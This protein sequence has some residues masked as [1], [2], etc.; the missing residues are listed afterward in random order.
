MSG[1][2]T[3]M[4]QAAALLLVAAALGFVIGRAARR[5]PVA[6]AA[7][8]GVV[9]RSEPTGA[10]AAAVGGNSPLGELDPPGTGVPEEMPAP[11]GVPAEAEAVS[12][13]EQPVAASGEPVPST[14]SATAAEDPENPVFDAV[15]LLRQG[16]AEVASPEVAAGSAEP[17]DDLA[18]EST[19]EA[20]AD[21]GP[22]TPSADGSE[23][24]ADPAEVAAL[25]RAK[26][27]EIGRLESGALTALERTISRFQGRVDDL[28]ARLKDATSRSR[29]LDARAEEEA[30]RARRL[31]ETL[32]RRD[33]DVAELRD[34]LEARR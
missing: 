9:R 31:Q 5:G 20:V 7:P 24:P 34:R 2:A 1:F 29:E 19:S 22:V 30:L 18:P 10:A 12:M 33:A 14:Q 32:A 26:D 3:L 23:V 28:E 21:A 11:D 8:A 17:V 16:V 4:L 6:P 25:L 15:L 13:S 27:A